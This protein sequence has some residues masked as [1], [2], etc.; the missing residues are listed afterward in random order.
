MKATLGDC[1][2]V[3]KPKGSGKSGQRKHYIQSPREAPPRG[4]VHSTEPFPVR[5][6]P[7]TDASKYQRPFLP[8][9]LCA[10]QGLCGLCT[11][12]FCMYPQASKM[13]FWFSKTTLLSGFA[14][15]LGKMYLTARGQ[16]RSQCLLPLSS[17]CPV[18][19][20]VVWWADQV[21]RKEWWGDYS[22]IELV[23]HLLTIKWRFLV[24]LEEYGLAGKATNLGLEEVEFWTLVMTW[25]NDVTSL[26]LSYLISK[27]GWLY[28]LPRD[29]SDWEKVHVS[30]VFSI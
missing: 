3:N 2:A 27:M 15:F 23:L 13:R 8:E 29:I 28:L 6:Q 19:I 7:I 24:Q 20:L 10:P 16:S 9:S 11:W 1:R 12:R 5:L 26:S 25:P 30:T 14:V 22:R 18:L 17:F 4:V 21:Y